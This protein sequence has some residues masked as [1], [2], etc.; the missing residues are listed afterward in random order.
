MTE[1][2]I[3]LMSGT[4]RDG[5]DAVLAAYDPQTGWRIL[6]HQHSPYPLSLSRELADLTRNGQGSF[7]QIGQMDALIG[8]AF[9]A[10]ALGLLAQCAVSPTAVRAIGSHGQTLFH[11]PRAEAPFT[12]QI[13]DPFRIAERTGIDTVAW[14]RQ[15]DL[16]AGGEGAPLVCAFHAAVFRHPLHHRAIINLGG[17][18]NLTWLAPAD[19]VYGYDC[20]PGNTLL[21]AWIQRQLQQ[22]MDTDGQWAASG[23]VQEALCQAWL[24]DAYFHQPPPKST[25]PEHFSLDWLER[26]VRAAGYRVPP[27]GH[28][29]TQ[30]PHSSTMVPAGRTAAATG[31][32]TAVDVQASLTELTARVVAASVR[33]ECTQSAVPGCEVLLCGGGV[34]NHELVRRLAGHLPELRVR[35]TCD[36]GVPAGQVEALAFAWLARQTLEKQP[37]NLPAVTGAQGSRILG[38]VIPGG[39]GSRTG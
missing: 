36:V 37:G 9:A 33:R 35:P 27:P 21:D 3:G 20:G 18:A 8:E 6:G 25:G 29:A 2:F 10:A 13:G 28:A 26:G 22:S 38:C 11:A 16:A 4:S 34:H 12:W 7:L 32:L 5:I 39:T 24:Q 17:I 19:T 30:T 14:F 15:R 23:V 1:L 31:T